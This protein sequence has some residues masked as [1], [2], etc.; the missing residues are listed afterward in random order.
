MFAMNDLILNFAIS[1]L[2]CLN[3]TSN[4]LSLKCIFYK[5]TSKMFAMN[6]LIL[7][8]SISILNCLNITSNDVSLKC[9]T[10]QNYIKDVSN[11]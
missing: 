11:E 1:N 6:D 3:I 7:N 5:I 2:N 8:F 4:D 10:L 9:F